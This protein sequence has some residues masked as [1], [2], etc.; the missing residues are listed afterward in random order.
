[1]IFG[2][3]LKKSIM[4]NLVLVF[5]AVVALFSFSS[6]EKCLNCVKV[7]PECGYCDYGANGN[8]AAVC[9]SGT[10]L[11]YSQAKSDCQAQGGT[12]K[13]SQSTSTDEQKVCGN[14]SSAAQDKATT[15]QLNGYTCN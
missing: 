2:A 8:S 9:K 3:E 5:C 14:S 13:I 7:T 12:W 10:G 15:F 4:K 11:D 1:V 6:C